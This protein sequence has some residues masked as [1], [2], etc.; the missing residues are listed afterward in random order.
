MKKFVF[1]HL[2]S[3]ANCFYIL[4]SQ[5]KFDRSTLNS[6]VKDLLKIIK[7][8]DMTGDNVHSA[9]DSE[10]KD[11]EDALQNFSAINNADISIIITRDKKHFTASSLI[12]Q[13]PQEFLEINDNK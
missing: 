12:V 6:V 3:L 4:G 5:Y 9:L 2:L 8:T 10:F 1:I 13:T 7:V 11:F